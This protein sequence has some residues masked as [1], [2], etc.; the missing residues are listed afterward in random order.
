MHTDDKALVEN[1]VKIVYAWIYAALRDQVF[2]SVTELNK[3]IY[4]ELEK[5]NS[6]KMQKPGISRFESFD[7]IERNVLGNLPLDLYESISDPEFFFN[8]MLLFSAFFIK[9]N[10]LKFELFVIFLSS[11]HSK[12]ASIYF[13]CLN[14]CLYYR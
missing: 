4:K 2:Y 3:A 13:F 6:K 10:G 5:Y 1:A 9:Y 8:I 14:I 12:K 11:S 7:N